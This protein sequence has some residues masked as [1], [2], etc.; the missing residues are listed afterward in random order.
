VADLLAMRGQP[1]GSDHKREKARMT[2]KRNFSKGGISKLAAYNACRYALYAFRAR[3]RRGFPIC[4]RWLDVRVF[5]REVEEEL[6]PPPGKG[7]RLVPLDDDLVLKPGSVEWS[8]PRRRGGAEGVDAAEE[9]AALVRFVEEER[10]SCECP[11][12]EMQ[13]CPCMRALAVLLAPLI[14]TEL[15]EPKEDGPTQVDPGD[16]EEDRDI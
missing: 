13:G 9:L 7:W 4:D 8:P 1:V 15:A 12:E 3:N 6:G 5:V 16:I 2:A 14:E 11:E 10:F